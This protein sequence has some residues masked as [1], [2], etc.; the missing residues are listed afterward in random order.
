M[1]PFAS[2][3]DAEMNAWSRDPVVGIF[4]EADCR[5]FHILL[6]L[7]FDLDIN[8]IA[9]NKHR[10]KNHHMIDPCNS[11]PFSPDIGDS[12]LLQQG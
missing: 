6:P 2:S 4:M 8:Y 3:A 10:Y 7:P 12:H 1:L 11:I 5:S 9:R